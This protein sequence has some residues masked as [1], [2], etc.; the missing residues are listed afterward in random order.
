MSTST[1][2]PVRLLFIGLD[3]ALARRVRTLFDHTREYLAIEWIDQATAGHLRLLAN[4][5]DI[6]LIAGSAADPAVLGLIGRATAGGCDVPIV[7]LADRRPADAAIERRLFAAGAVDIWPEGDVTPPLLKHAVQ[8]A[9]RHRETLVLL[10]IQRARLALL[11]SIVESSDDAILATSPDGTIVSWSAGAER[12]FGY[13]AEEAIGMPGERLVPEDRHDE[14]AADFERLRT[15]KRVGR[16]ETVRVRKDG[17][18]IHVSLAVAPTLDGQGEL[19]GASMVARDVS[20]RVIAQTAI[21]ESER[22]HRSTFEAGPIAVAHIAS[23]GRTIRA[24]RRYCELVGYPEHELRDLDVTGLALPGER[25]QNQAARDAM[26]AGTLA[27][28]VCETRYH[29]RDGSEVWV[30]L[31]TTM[32]RDV[33]GRP[34]YFIDALEDITPRKR[35]EEKRAELEEQLRQVHKMEAVGRLAGGIAHDFNNLLTAI[36][37]YAALLLDEL[38]PADPAR[39]D[40]EEIQKA[41]QTAASLTTQL[42]AFSRRQMLQPQIIN[43]NTIVTN[44]KLL[45]QRLIGERIELFTSLA[46]P[47]EQVSADQSQ[48]EQVI[49]NLAVNARDA[50]PQGGRLTLETANV[51]IDRAFIAAHRGAVAGPHV[52]LAIRDTGTGMDAEV[53]THL[54]EPF[55]TTKERGKGTGL[56]LATVYGIVKQSQGYIAVDSE[57]GRGSTFSVYLPATDAAREEAPAGHRMPAATRG[58]ETVLLVEDQPE[59]RTITRET[60]ARN[61]YTVVEASNGHEALEWLQR[62]ERRIDLLLTD[63]VMPGIGGRELAS[64]V[65]ARQHD[66]RVLFMS[67]YADD[68]IG[69]RGV[70]ESGLDFIQKPFMSDNLLRRVREVLD[71]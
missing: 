5:H 8:A 41:G 48:I 44:M 26:V 23:N 64:A 55:Y 7:V 53:M 60:L 25:A 18:E 37:G 21:I 22:A 59:V 19:A 24:N 52:M 63:V 32:H 70:V 33:S 2:A 4:D 45:L 30:S 71:R 13:P 49:M 28:Y 31:N 6:A 56:G 11:S 36:L 1:A 67:G 69:D 15:G 58:T 46:S 38:P 39:R 40:I 50:M 68:V 16:H 17:R 20:E 27:R 12:L 54:F 43:L 42:L 9:I 35:A 51:V 47:L 62:A 66:I 14:L 3:G 57:P 61:G 34:L 10:K 65:A 29:R